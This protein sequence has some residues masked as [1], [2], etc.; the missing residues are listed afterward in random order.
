MSI[1]M[2]LRATPESEIREDWTWLA[3]FMGGALDH[4]QDELRAG[5]AEMVEYHF[6]A[7]HE[8][9]RAAYE[10]QGS[11]EWEL[12]I[13]GGS[14]VFE[15]TRDHPPFVILRPA[16]VREA[17]DFLTTASFDDLWEAARPTVL[18]PFSA[19]DEAEVKGWFLGHHTD[20]H[21]FYSRTAS[22][23]QAVVKAFWY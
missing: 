20:L 3:E 22:A 23:G 10:P 13:F 9:Y 1:N 19:F 15:A 7:L 21:A 6:H 18:P 2:Q 16:V 4:F 14:P 5:I 8:V 11:W 12:P 17:A